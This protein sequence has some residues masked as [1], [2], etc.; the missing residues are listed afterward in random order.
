MCSLPD[1]DPS[2]VRFSRSRETASCQ[3]CRTL[4]LG[5]GC[6]NVIV[7]SHDIVSGSAAAPVAQNTRAPRNIFT[8]FPPTGETSFSGRPKHIPGRTPLLL[9]TSIEFLPLERRAASPIFH[10]NSGQPERVGDTTRLIIQNRKTP[11]RW[12]NARSPAPQEHSRRDLESTRCSCNSLSKPA[13]L[14]VRRIGSQSSGASPW[15]RRVTLLDRCSPP[16]PEAD[17][18]WCVCWL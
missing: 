11:K 17:V 13:S 10:P 3:D 9:S 1:S 7:P 2:R 15:R 6:A 16:R 18:H 14:A 5:C 12:L 8:A 4:L